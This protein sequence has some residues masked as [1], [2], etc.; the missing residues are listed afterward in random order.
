M[1]ITVLVGHSSPETAHVTE[2]SPYGFR[3]RCQRR[4]WLECHPTK[5]YRFVTQT[6]NPKRPGLVWNA[7]KA[8][9]YTSLGVMFLDD[10]QHVQW[11]RLSVYDS[12]ATIDRFAAT[13]PE[14]LREPRERR[15]LGMLRQGEL[16]LEERK[17]CRAYLQALPKDLSL[18]SGVL[19]A[20][21]AW[22]LHDGFPFWTTDVGH[23]YV[24]PNAA[25]AAACLA[26]YPLALKD[27]TVV[28]WPTS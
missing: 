26:A 19:L 7:P 4:A 21:K 3:L 16:L 23:A 11:A 5:G 1:S 13:Y 2:D 9:T 15:I 17:A 6:S 10:A 20:Q 25:T 22:Y 8:S 18:A 27:T 12:L 24:F 14:G 28:V